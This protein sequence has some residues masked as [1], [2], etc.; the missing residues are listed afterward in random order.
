MT[1]ALKV[2]VEY[3][4]SNI[5]IHRIEAHVETGNGNS[6]KLLKKIGFKKEGLL[7]ERLYYKGKHQS[8]MIYSLLRTD[9]INTNQLTQ[10]ILN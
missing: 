6:E 1:E 5:G 4:F 2:F 3:G 10:N 7:R 9:E 8:L